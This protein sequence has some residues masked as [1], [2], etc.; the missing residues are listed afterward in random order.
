MERKPYHRSR[1]RM[2]NA[3]GGAGTPT[4]AV[5]RLALRCGLVAP[6]ERTQVR[7]LDTGTYLLT[8]TATGRRWRVDLLTQDY[9]EA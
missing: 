4:Q 9:T 1:S 5:R 8:H 3:A 2:R 7:R 6:G